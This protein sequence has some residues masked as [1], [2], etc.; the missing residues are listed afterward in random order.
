MRLYSAGHCVLL[1]TCLYSNE[2]KIMRRMA[3][4]IAL[5]TLTLA[6]AAS[7]MVSPSSVQGARPP[8][9][10]PEPAAA[11]LFAAG[12]GIS[13]WAMRRRSHRS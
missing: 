5:A 11:L 13:A 3:F 4:A 2:G 1:L 6:G 8:S 10:V 12:L 7:A 9:A